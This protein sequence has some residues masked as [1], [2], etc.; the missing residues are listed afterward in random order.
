MGDVLRADATRVH[1]S[2]ELVAECEIMLAQV[3]G[4]AC[5]ERS[6][7]SPSAST[8]TMAEMRSVRPLSPALAR[9]HSRAAQLLAF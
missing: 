1:L 6:T 2:D 4:V 9:S 8:S 7:P 3:R 5:D